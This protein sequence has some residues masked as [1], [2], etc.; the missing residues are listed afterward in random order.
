MTISPLEQI[1]VTGAV[2]AIVPSVASV[3][4]HIKV[5][6]E[7]RANYNAMNA[8]VD[9]I[10]ELLGNGAEGTFMRRNECELVHQRM[11][12]HLTRLDDHK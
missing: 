12:E 7:M 6:V 4:G 1:L 10:E 3:V 5:V 11:Q 8:R 2:A 9:K